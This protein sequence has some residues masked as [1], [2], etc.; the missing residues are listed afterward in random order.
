MCEAHLGVEWQQVQREPRSSSC[1]SHS[2][3]RLFN[4]SASSPHLPIRDSANKVNIV[5]Q[6][7][8]QAFSLT[9]QRNLGAP[10]VPHPEMFFFFFSRKK[11]HTLMP[12]G[13]AGLRPYLASKWAVMP[14][15]GYV[16]F[17]K[18]SWKTKN[19]ALAVFLWLGLQFLI[20]IFGVW[21]VTARFIPHFCPEHE[22]NV[23]FK[24]SNVYFEYCYS[25][26]D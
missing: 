15:Q 25:H 4:V 22:N 21:S 7:A 18:V 3:G 13:V 24:N 12:G 19:R 10:A 14:W 17:T 2:T 20:E 11:K 9:R 5:P 1:F 16:S 23:C 6:A 8:M 26:W